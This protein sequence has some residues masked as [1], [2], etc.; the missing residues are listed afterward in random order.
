MHNSRKFFD[1]FRNYRDLERPVAEGAGGARELR[2]RLSKEL[3]A[4]YMF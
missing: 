2:R 1:F 4:D 3:T